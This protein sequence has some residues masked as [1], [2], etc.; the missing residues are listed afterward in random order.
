MVVEP[1]DD[2]ELLMT[3]HFLPG[4]SRWFSR[5]AVF[6]LWLVVESH[7]AEILKLLLCSVKV[8]D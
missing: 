1:Y 2:V 7:H 3:S 4:F 8:N 6:A 5:D